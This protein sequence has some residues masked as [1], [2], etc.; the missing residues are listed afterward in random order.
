MV[1][2]GMIGIGGIG[3]VHIDVL[4]GLPNARVTACCTR[5][6]GRMR[7][8]C[9]GIED[10]GRANAAIAASRLYTDYR[11]LVRDPEV[12]V[13]DICL[14]TDMHEAVTLAALEAGKHVICEK[15]MA[16][17][18]AGCDRMISAAQAAGKRL[19][20]AHCIRFWPEYAYLKSLVDGGQ[21]GAVRYAMFRRLSPAPDWTSS[22]WMVD[23]VRSGGAI[24]D[25]HVH[26][27]DFVAYLLGMPRTVFAVG[28]EAPGTG[29]RE[30][31][32]EYTYDA[33][34][35]ILAEACNNYPPGFPFRMTFQVQF[36]RAAVEFDRG[37]LTVYPHDGA[38]VTPSLEG[39][40]YLNE[41]IYFLDCLE[42]NIDPEDASAWSARETI[43]LIEAER[44]S[45]RTGQ[46]V[47]LS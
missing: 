47:A 22:D 35:L 17:T 16:L 40:G 38:S 34:G 4:A 30:V 33:P 29:I 46:P 25:L 7:R 19:M 20:V 42:R 11:E 13:V 8:N 24:T 18:V 27:A 41:M 1:N 44:E 31:V 2:F 9:A 10:I 45:A 5:D 36:D 39:N 15:P 14:P 3:L 12:D 23:P 21:Y 32:A 43:R 28:L 26:D 6:P 37:P